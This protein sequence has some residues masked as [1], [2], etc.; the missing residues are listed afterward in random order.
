MKPCISFT[1]PSNPTY[2]PDTMLSNRN[3][4]KEKRKRKTNSR[5]GKIRSKE[6]TDYFY[7][8]VRRQLPLALE[9]TT[10]HPCSR[11]NRPTTPTDKPERLGPQMDQRPKTQTKLPNPLAQCTMLHQTCMTSTP[12]CSPPSTTANHPDQAAH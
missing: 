9:A 10:I 3:R 7:H 1:I 6:L 4:K 11:T 5:T 12:S 2:I 8:Q